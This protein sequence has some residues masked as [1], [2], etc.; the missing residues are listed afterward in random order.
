MFHLY[1]EFIR[2][3]FEIFIFTRYGS[4]K[5]YINLI[6]ALISHFILKPEILNYLP[7]RIYVDPTNICNL[8]CP[9]CPTGRKEF[10]RKPGYMRFENFKK[11]VDEI[12]E[13][14]FEIDF[15]FW[16]EPLLNKQ[17]FKMIKYAHEKNIRTRISSNLNFDFSVEELVDSGL[18]ELIVSCDGASEETYRKYRVGGSFSKV[19]EKIR[20]IQ[21]YKRKNKRKNPRI[22]WQ[23]LVMSH[24]EHEIKKAKK[25]AKELGV[26]LR[27]LPIRAGLGYDIINDHRG[28]K[29]INWIAKKITRYKKDG[30]RK[31][32][33]KSCLFLWFQTFVNWD[34][35]ISPC[36]GAFYE[37][38]DFGN[39]FIQKFK[40]VWNGEKYILARRIVKNKITEHKD[41][42]CTNCV[43]RGYFV[44]P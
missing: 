16:G 10:G 29:Y 23:F 34:G 7:P 43:E 22:V 17:I 4:L 19:M 6:K 18:D 12:G 28:N 37:K 30:S 39:V 25:M 35:S 36:C 15:Y 8:R 32:K 1:K 31:F 40:D 14:L 3:F 33:I 26:R 5:K 41:F 38:D 13:T 44:D 21:E 24:N 20:E 9:L 11:I 27:I 2:S 42:I